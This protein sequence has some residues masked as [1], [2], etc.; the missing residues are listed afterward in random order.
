[1]TRESQQLLEKRLEVFRKEHLQEGD[2]RRPVRLVSAAD[3][4]VDSDPALALRI[5]QR[6][7]VLQPNSPVIK[8]KIKTTGQILKQIEPDVM[9]SSSSESN[10]LTDK[11]DVPQI[12]TGDLVITALQAWNMKEL[13]LRPLVLLVILPFL[14]FAIYLSLLAS[15]RFESQSQIIVQQP[16]GASTLDPSMA[17]LS[18]LTGKSASPDT[19]LVEVFMQSS[20]LLAYLEETIG[21]SEHFSNSNADV[22]SRLA[23]NASFEDRLAYYQTRVKVEVDDASKVIKLKTQAYTPEYARLLNETIVSRAE[24]YINKIGNQLAE[25]Q[26][27]FVKREHEQVESRLQKAKQDLLSFQRRYNLLDPVAEGMALQQI[28]Y[29]LEGQI[30][31]KEAELRAL[32]G[33]MSDTASPVIQAREQ[34]KSL[35]Q[36]LL[37]ERTRLTK[38]RTPTS[39]SEV[40]GVNEVQARF[41]GLKTELEF[42][43]EAL[44]ASL[45]SLEKSRIE[46]YRQLKYLVV[47][48]TSTLPEDARYP[49]TFYSLALFLA[50]SL[51]MFGIGRI[52][53]ATVDELR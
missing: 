28:T 38:D 9:R 50:V 7:R 11:S 32:K 40:I 15:D 29:A 3:K 17:L 23:S 21:F 36:Q 1:M 16:N 42:A 10:R 8:Q 26:L 2:W 20:D 43:L 51:M 48:E 31:A 18:G 12:E 39:G 37:E 30:A 4:L 49:R 35:K 41:A 46:A 44:S 24:W 6:A 27:T 22:F 45:V 53:L 13:L 33:S 52:I 47:V 19:E 25:A 5:Y 34:L 14:A